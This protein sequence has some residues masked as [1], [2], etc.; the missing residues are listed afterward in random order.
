MEIKEGMTFRLGEEIL[1]MEPNHRDEFDME[2]TISEVDDDSVT[3][4]WEPID[5]EPETITYRMVDVR[6]FIKEGHWVFQ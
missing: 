4:T 6:I 3:V 2:Y 1:E 5:G